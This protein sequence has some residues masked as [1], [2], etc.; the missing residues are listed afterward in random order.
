MSTGDE[1]EEALKAMQ[2]RKA[3]GKLL[4]IK[5]ILKKKTKKNAKMVDG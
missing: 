4:N 5:K 1:V 2:E 3:A